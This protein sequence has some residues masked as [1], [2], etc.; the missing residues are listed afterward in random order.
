M[1][2]LDFHLVTLDLDQLPVAATHIYGPHPGAATPAV[3]DWWLGNAGESLDELAAAAP[4]AKTTASAK[5]R[6]AIFM[7]G[8]L[9]RLKLTENSS[10]V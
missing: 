8:N 4:P 5:M 2:T 9:P 1:V 7:I 10:S 6:I 3:A